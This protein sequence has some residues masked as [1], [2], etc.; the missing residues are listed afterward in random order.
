[1]TRPKKLVVCL[2]LADRATTSRDFP[3]P[4]RFLEERGYECRD[5]GLPWSHPAGR[6]ARVLRL[7]PLLRRADLVITTEYFLAASVSAVLRLS[8]S[9]AKHAVLGLNISSNRTLRTRANWLNRAINGL[10]FGRID[11]AVVASKPEAGIFSR[12]HA[13]PRERFAFV[14]WAYDLPEGKGAFVPPERPYFC[15]IGRNNRDQRTFCRA[16]EGLPADGVIVSHTAP[17][18]ALPSNVHSLV[19]I[20]YSDCIDCIRQAV[21]NVILVQ[22]A[23]RGAG[24]ITMVTAMHCARPQIISHV[25]TALDY[26]IPG[27]HALTV[28]VADMGAVREAMQTLLNDPALADRMGQAAAAHAAQR[29]THARR[30]EILQDRIRT[31]YDTGRIDWEEREDGQPPETGTATG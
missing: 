13:I 3:E 7:A 5:I 8:G 17:D 12:V 26:F 10:F 22:D 9:R 14:H 18:F 23:E 4:L 24:H 29:L 15:L 11:M 31:W 30:T 19:E 16:L 21:A 2:S 28:P 1:M 25:D 6:L 20:P 27:E